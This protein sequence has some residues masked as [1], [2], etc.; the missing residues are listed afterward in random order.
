MYIYRYL[1]HDKHFTV[2]SY[3]NMDV[4]SKPIEQCHGMI[5][6]NIVCEDDD[7][8]GRQQVTP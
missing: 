3:G 8:W 2:I 7:E 1:L 4:L 6:E 5:R